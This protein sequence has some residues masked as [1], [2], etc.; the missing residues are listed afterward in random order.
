MD[1]T[2]Q[3]ETFLA[4]Q[5]QQKYPLTTIQLSALRTLFSDPSV[6][7][8]QV[9]KQISGPL[10]DSVER[11][12]KG[13]SGEY[14]PDAFWR[15]I[16]DAVRTLTSFNDRLVEFMVELQKVEVKVSDGIP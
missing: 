12:M 15:T 16:L 7:V 8:S 10:I 4:S 3:Y 14:N 9:A 5:Q 11:I 13:K 1:S 2:S 6:P